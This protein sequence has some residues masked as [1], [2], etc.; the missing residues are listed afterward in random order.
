MLSFA[1]ENETVS[2]QLI[3]LNRLYH[4]NWLQPHEGP[5]FDI[6]THAMILVP[7]TQ[8]RVQTRVLRD[9]KVLEMLQTYI[10][11]PLV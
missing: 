6:G 7:E 5:N 1:I 8:E 2:K 9:P 3:D 10:R 4:Y 11:D